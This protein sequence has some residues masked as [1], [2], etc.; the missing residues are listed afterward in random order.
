MMHSFII[1]NF[2]ILFVENDAEIAHFVYVTEAIW[3]IIKQ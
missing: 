3:L 2:R 1:E